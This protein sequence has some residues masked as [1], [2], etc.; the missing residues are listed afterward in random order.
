MRKDGSPRVATWRGSPR[1]IHDV[2]VLVDEH[3]IAAPSHH[4]YNEQKSVV[5]AGGVPLFAVQ[6]EHALKPRLANRA[7]VSVAQV[8]ASDQAEGAVA[9][10]SPRGQDRD[11][12]N[13]AVVEVCR[14]EHIGA[15]G[16]R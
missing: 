9:F 8:L 14:Q 15:P 1:R 10:D 3:E 5:L 13:A 11:A 12:L 4:F 16:L 6:L 7:D 2:S